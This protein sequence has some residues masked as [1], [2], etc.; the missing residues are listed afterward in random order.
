MILRLNIFEPLK[1]ININ[2]NKR[3]IIILKYQDKADNTSKCPKFL[4]AVIN[5]SIIMRNKLII[6]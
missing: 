2:I 3:I 5:Q 6:F 4:Q 1:K